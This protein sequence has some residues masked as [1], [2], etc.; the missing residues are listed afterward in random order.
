MEMETITLQTPM[1]TRGGDSESQ[2]YPQ[3]SADDAVSIGC[4][5]S[6]LDRSGSENSD[7]EDAPPKKRMKSVIFPPMPSAACPPNPKA[8]TRRGTY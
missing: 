1:M 5:Y 8:R 6:D 4:A 3:E 7:D 2:G